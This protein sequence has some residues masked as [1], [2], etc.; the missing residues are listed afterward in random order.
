MI[1]S[2]REGRAVFVGE[3][4]KRRTEFAKKQNE[5]VELHRKKSF[6]STGGTWTP[7]GRGEEVEG[8]VVREGSPGSELPAYPQ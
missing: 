8:L 2:S 7:R 4:P 1:E 3:V 5:Y 6:R